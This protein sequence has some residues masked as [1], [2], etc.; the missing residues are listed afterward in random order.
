MELIFT[1]LI[2]LQ[3]LEQVFHHMFSV[4]IYELGKVSSIDP[5]Y[6]SLNIDTAR[7]TLFMHAGNSM[8]RI[9]LKYSVQ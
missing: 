3:P 7:C 5:Q 6:S 1:K 9:Q 4:R 8:P 2:N